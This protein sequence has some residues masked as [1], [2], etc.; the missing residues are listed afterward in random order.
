MSEGKIDPRLLK[1]YRPSEWETEIYR[2]WEA[3]DFF[4]PRGDGP[5]FSLVLPPPNVTGQLHLGHAAMLAIEDILVRYR[6]MR[7]ARTLWLPGTDHAA[8]A[9]QAKVEKELQKSEGKTKHDLGREEF[10]RRVSAFARESHDTIIG[11][12]KKM[13]CSLDWS[14]EAYTLDETRSRAVKMAFQE[15]REAG[16]IY[17]GE[18]LVNWDPRLQ[19]TIS[20]DEI[21]YREEKTKFYYLKY[22]PFVIGTARPETKFGDKYVVMHPADE[23]YRE[24]ES[25]QKIEL[26]WINGPIVATVI[27]DESVDREFGTG[28]M[29]IT[30]CHDAHD[31]ELAQ[32]HHLDREPVIDLRGKLLPLAGEFA[33]LHIK[34]VRLLIVEKLRAKGLIEKIDENYVHNLALSERSEEVIEPQVMK[35]WF[36][37]VNQKFPAKTDKIDGIK[38]GQEITLKEL[39]QQVVRSGQIK[40]I[41]E[42]FAKTYFNWVDNLRDWCVSRQIWFGHPVPATLTNG[43]PD[44]DTLDTWFSSGLWTF[45]T[46]L[47]PKEEAPTLAEWLAKSPDRIYHPTSVLETGYD[48]LFFWVARMILMTGFLLGEIPFPTV[49]LHGLVRDQQNRKLSKSLGNAGDPLVMIAKYGADAVRMSL[50]VGT[51]PGNDSKIWPDKIK[52]YQ[53][54]A[55]KVWNISRFI[56]EHPA[57][58]SPAGEPAAED[59]ELLVEFKKLASE[60]TADLE[61]YRF[62]LAAEKLYHY[63][64]HRFADEILE[65]AKKRPPTPLLAQIWR[66]ALKLLHPFMPFVT[67]A[68][69]SLGFAR[70]KSLGFA[71]QDTPL[72]TEIWPPLS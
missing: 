9:T 8:I 55:N 50:V 14:R 62:Y 30:P 53:H 2:R 1:P 64:W 37:A 39:L 20:D 32:K 25:G 47:D 41:P 17:R 52:A 45:S 72:I 34:K 15:M 59:G 16:L 12:I 51:A 44:P 31:F 26:E 27:K 57:A 10:L 61:S 22:G 7:G 11:Q 3:G 60:V 70:D 42:R 48:I 24:Y 36:V 68:V 66:E 65:A 69:W 5:V 19:T 43:E 28:V 18:R 35:Q 6:R 23:R 71:N 56:L 54:F 38:K 63:I 29:T 40:I 46:L 4:S 21:V 33:G 49:Y 58:D 67:E 13:G